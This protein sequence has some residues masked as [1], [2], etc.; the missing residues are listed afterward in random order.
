MTI[1]VVQMT[2]M[3]ILTNNSSNTF[4]KNS[5][6]DWWLWQYEDITNN[7]IMMT[8]PELN[9]NVNNSTDTENTDAK[10][11]MIIKE[12]ERKSAMT[13]IY[14]DVYVTK[15]GATCWSY[16]VVWMLEVYSFATCCSWSDPVYMDSTP[17]TRWDAW[18]DTSE[19]R[20]TC[21]VWYTKWRMQP[22]ETIAATMNLPEKVDE[23]AE[24]FVAAA[25]VV[26]E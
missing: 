12:T 24:A 8:N 7:D 10:K 13:Q 17:T 5:N 9:F 6:N 23:D 3:Q 14:C 15:R 1:K 19:W 2:K 16:F 21:K 4:N 18:R 25:A 22:S 20:V 26:W 11:T